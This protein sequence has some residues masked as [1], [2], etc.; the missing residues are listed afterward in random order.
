MQSCQ[1]PNKTALCQP[2]SQGFRHLRK[3]LV[4]PGGSQTPPSTLSQEAWVFLSMGLI[5]PMAW[6]QFCL[7][8]LFS[9]V[10]L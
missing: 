9:I 5:V 2:A 3:V 6:C 7:C 4:T 1:Q 8:P 10:W